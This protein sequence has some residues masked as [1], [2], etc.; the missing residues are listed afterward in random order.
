MKIIAF[1]GLD[2]S[3]KHTQTNKLAD[4]LRS[5]GFKVVQSEFH[6]YDTPTGK[7]IQEYL[8]KRYNANDTVVELLM[9]ADKVAQREWFEE[10]R[11]DGV[12]FLILDRY[13]ACQHSYGLAK[14][15]DEKLVRMLSTLVEEPTL[16]ILVDISPETS[17]SRK[18]QHGENDRYESNR[19]FLSKV[20]TEYFNYFKENPNRRYVMRDVDN[21]SVEQ[22]SKRIDHLVSE[23]F[24]L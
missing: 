10:L 8:Y 11:Q 3:G 24:L 23:Y 6:R 22:L 7:L 4:G 16:E 18:G 12:D 19:Q 17:M 13:V 14:G 2:K 15:Q 1:S 20:R 9:T 21:L 5:K